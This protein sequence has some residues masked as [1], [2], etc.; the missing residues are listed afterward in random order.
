M[1]VW[2]PDSSEGPKSNQ[3]TVLLAREP[4]R[5]ASLRSSQTKNTSNLQVPPPLS[6]VS[7]YSSS[8]VLHTLWLILS[9]W[10]WLCLMIQGFFK[11]QSGG[12]TVPS[13]ILQPSSL[14]WI[15]RH[16]IL[17]KKKKK[18]ERME[19][20]WE[21]KRTKGNKNRKEEWKGRWKETKWHHF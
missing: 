17:K 11:T 10:C 13:N 3:L 2:K 9:P 1:L 8:W 7:L 19:K 20:R 21:E 6:Y 15:T 14:S 12:F 4:A 16:H 18:K 5:E